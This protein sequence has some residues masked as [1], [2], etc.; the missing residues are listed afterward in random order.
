MNKLSTYWSSLRTSD[1]YF[2]ISYALMM[3]MMALLPF[4][5]FFM[6]PIGVMLMLL[7]ICPGTWREKWENF[8]QNDGIPYGFFLLGIC[9]IPLLGF[10]NSE[11][12]PIAWRSF[13]AHLWFFFTPLIFLTSSSKLWSKRHVQTLLLIFSVSEIILLLFLFGHGIFKMWATGDTA[14][15]FNNLFCYKRHHAYIS[16]Y[17]NFVY[18]LIFQY[19]IENFDRISR[20]RKILLFGLALFISV[21]IFYAYSRAGILIFLFMHLVWCFYAIHLKRSSWKVMIALAMSMFALFSTL[22]VTAPIN[23]F[24]EDAIFFHRKPGDDREIDPRRVIW[25]ASKE[26]AI[27]NLPWG[28]GTGDGNDVIVEYYH[29]NGYWLSSEHSFNA[30][31]Q[32]LFAMLTNGIPGFII[33]LLFF[34]APLGLAIRHKDIFLLS[35]FLL[36]TLNC[37]VE[38]MFD[39]RAGVD[40]FA[41]MI[42]L[43]IIRTHINTKNNM[44]KNKIYDQI[45]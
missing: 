38:C 10:I 16:L 12:K 4:T 33:I 45:C 42:P 19:L 34:F 21:C 1:V 17:A 14:Y 41:V 24:T 3:I 25:M 39:R 28:V 26:A 7:W 27:D 11:N 5:T 32:F 29:R 43:F 15:M 9:L 40:F 23:R 20:I 37:L 6:W 2:N 35:L 30:H 44:T 31:N 13:E 8:K 36:M 18:L 22:I